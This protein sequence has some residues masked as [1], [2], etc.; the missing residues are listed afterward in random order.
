MPDTNNNK[1]DKKKVFTNGCSAKKTILNTAR[2]VKVVSYHPK[3]IPNTFDSYPIRESFDP[4]ANCEINLLG[5]FSE[6]NTLNNN[7]TYS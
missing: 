7:T 3:G 6:L 5:V 4:I 1:K 2:R